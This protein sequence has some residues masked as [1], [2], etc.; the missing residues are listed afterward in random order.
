MGGT[1]SI[2]MMNIRHLGKIITKMVWDKIVMT[3]IDKKGNIEMIY[4]VK[5]KNPKIKNK[6][7]EYSNQG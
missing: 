5:F 4:I 7:N 1:S 2:V 6:G 3:F